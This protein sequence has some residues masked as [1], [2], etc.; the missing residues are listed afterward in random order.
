MPAL[1]ERHTTM[2]VK[3]P[4]AKSAK[5]PDAKLV[6]RSHADK[7]KAAKKAKPSTSKRYEARKEKRETWSK[8]HP[9]LAPGEIGKQAS[10]RPVAPA[11]E[12]VKEVIERLATALEAGVV[13]APAPVDEK[14]VEEA[15]EVKQEQDA[16]KAAMEA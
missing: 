13:E 5:K 4:A 16:A 3:K 8:S 9:D 1:L 6:P 15:R 14:K 7:K 10:P 12:P 11:V 2:T